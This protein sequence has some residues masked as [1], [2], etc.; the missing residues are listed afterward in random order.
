MRNRPDGRPHRSVE[1]GNDLDAHLSSLWRVEGRDDAYR[2][3]PVLLRMH[4]LRALPA[5]QGGRLLRVLLLWLGP[6]PAATGCRVLP[7][8]R[9]EIDDEPGDGVCVRGD[10][11]GR[12]AA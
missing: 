10:G 3:L 12:P 1:F 4:G 7:L 6:L 9:P 2:R 5:S 8:S 11:D